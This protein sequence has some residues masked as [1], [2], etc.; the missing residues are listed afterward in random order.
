MLPAVTHTTHSFRVADANQRRSYTFPHEA[1]SVLGV[2]GDSEQQYADIF[3]QFP[4]FLRFSSTPALPDRD[5]MASAAFETFEVR[6]VAPAEQQIAVTISLLCWLLSVYRREPAVCVVLKHQVPGKTG[7]QTR[8]VPLIGAVNQDLTLG[9]DS[10]GWHARLQRSVEFGSVPLDRVRASLKR[11]GH[12]HADLLQQILIVWSDAA[13]EAHRSDESESGTSAAYPL[14]IRVTSRRREQ[15]ILVRYNRHL[16]TRELAE[17]LFEKYRMLLHDYESYRSQRLRDIELLSETDQLL[18]DQWNETAKEYDLTRPYHSYISR[19][20]AATPGAVAVKSGD[21]ELSYRELDDYANVL[22][23][24]LSERGVRCGDRVGQYVARSPEMLIGIVAVS[25]IGAILVP[26]DPQSPSDRVRYIL[27]DSGL[28]ILLGARNTAS[29]LQALLETRGAAAPGV[30]LIDDVYGSSTQPDIDDILIEDCRT[31]AYLIYTSGS[32]GKPKGVQVTHR[33]LINHN[34]ACQEIYGLTPLDSVL[35]LASIGFDHALEEMLPTLVSGARLVLYPDQQG[36]S[37]E[38]LNRILRIYHVT[39]FMPTTALWKPWAARSVRT[40]EFEFPHLRV[41]AIGGERCPKELLIAWL[42][43]CGRQVE[44]QAGYGVTEA[45]ITSTM[46]EPDPATLELDLMHEVPI[47]KPIGNTRLYIVDEYLRRVPIG[48]QGELCIAGEGVALGYWNKPA[49]TGK[50]FLIELGQHASRCMYRTGDIVKCT[51][52]GNLIYV[53]REDNQLKVNGYRVELTELEVAIATVPGVQECV[54][55]AHER[56]GQNYL[57]AFLRTE[58]GSRVTKSDL[59][60]KIPAYA[61]PCRLIEVRQFP[62][63]SSAKVDRQKL[64]R[65]AAAL[66]SQEALSADPQ[67]AR[68]SMDRAQAHEIVAATW[69][70]TLALTDIAPRANFFQIGGSSLLLVLVLEKLSSTLSR[71]IEVGA[72]LADPTIE[73]TVNALLGAQPCVDATNKTVTRG[74]TDDGRNQA[75]C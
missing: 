57:S 33:A 26:L 47:G 3:R 11:A 55:V 64:A 27:D 67:S 38:Q 71:R 73:G 51:A 16:L 42:A 28:R 66:H 37:V 31:T 68:E 43:L 10:D 30:L 74:E 18:L 22:A 65:E 13:T 25:K 14:Q 69:R 75:R 59:R 45:T 61:M 35:Q 21:A 36:I 40:G 52:N 34:L 50:R 12:E 62:L 15:R 39:V 53:T 58:H 19:W 44:L 56:G 70:E 54:V 4:S 32:T 72:I 49:E 24:M 6:A 20:A 48:A 9:E 17:G 46:W 29:R 2:D 1:H 5:D 23:R 8:E 63:N 7:L 41:C 60:D